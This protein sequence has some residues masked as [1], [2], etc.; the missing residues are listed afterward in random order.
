[1]RRIETMHDIGRITVF[2]DIS[3]PTKIDDVKN[4]MKSSHYDLYTKLIKNSIMYEKLFTE[5]VHIHDINSS[6]MAIQNKKPSI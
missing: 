5:Q 3:F 6:V 1:M 2:K 4:Q